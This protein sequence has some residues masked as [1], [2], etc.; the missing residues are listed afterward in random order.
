MDIGVN[1]EIGPKKE[2]KFISAKDKAKSTTEN[3]INSPPSTVTI[4][5]VFSSFI[6]VSFFYCW[7]RTPFCAIDDDMALM[8]VMALCAQL[9]A[10]RASVGSASENNS[11]CKQ[12]PEWQG[13]R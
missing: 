10:P 13:A 6:K 12:S 11:H 4:L 2:V 5:V 1:L 3:A 7:T 8:A 9:V